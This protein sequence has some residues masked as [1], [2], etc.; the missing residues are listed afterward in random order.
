MRLILAASGFFLSL[1]VTGCT[2]SV[3]GGVTDPEAAEQAVA[4]LFA[5]N[6]E[7]VL[8]QGS[9]A[10]ILN[11]EALDSAA[12]PDERKFVIQTDQGIFSMTQAQL[13]QYLA[14]RRA[15]EAEKAQLAA[16]QTG[17]ISPYGRVVSR[18]V[19]AGSTSSTATPQPAAR[20]KAPPIDPT[21]I[22]STKSIPGAFDQ[23]VGPSLALTKGPS[24]LKNADGSHACVLTFDD[25]PHHGRDAQI[26]D[27]LD[28]KGVKA[29]FFFLGEKVQANPN[30]AKEAKARGHEVGYHSWDHKNLR[31]E[32]LAT[33]QA[34]FT[35]GLAAFNAVGLRPKVFRPPFGNYNSGIIATAKKHGMSVVNWTNDSLDWKIKSA[36]GI[37]SRVLEQSAPGDIVLLHSIHE[38]SVEALPGIID[39]LKAQGCRFISMQSWITRATS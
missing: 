37:T 20:A 15:E 32:S 19:V 39:G 14:I 22:K 8:M 27:I 2:A 12:S 6:G 4:E 11:Q 7:R 25:G 9:A 24:D 31:A 10:D 30:T 23:Y 13:N 18:T 36:A 3:D 21:T 17:L 28:A 16:S 35:K 5:D 38:R 34:D 26:Y 29:M 33:V 1:L